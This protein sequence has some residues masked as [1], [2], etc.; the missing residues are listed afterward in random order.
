LAVVIALLVV[1][2]GATAVVWVNRT[3]HTKAATVT[4]TPVL[5]FKVIA[6]SPSPST[7]VVPSATNITVSFSAPIAQNSPKPTL[8]PPVPGDWAL[9][10]PSELEFVAS[11]PLVPGAT[12]SVVIPGGSAGM[13]S[14]QGQFLSTS[15]TVPFSVET[16]SILRLQ[17]LLAELGYLPLTFTP[18]APV[19]SLTQEADIQQGTFGWRWA[20]EPVS[21]T[22]L[23]TPGQMNVITRGAIMDFEDQ[24]GLTTDGQ[25]G[26]QVWTDLL[27]D[28][29]SG[30]ADS[31]PYRYVYVSENLPETVT[32]Y[33]D[34]AVVYTTLANTG[35]PGATTQQGT[36]PVFARYVTTTMTGTNVDGSKYSDPGVPWVS[37]FN[38]G[39]ALHGFVRGSY[40]FPQS[41][42]CVEMP[43]SNAAV[44]FPLTP[45]GTLVTV[46]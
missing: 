3:G 8:A 38:G 11:A 43:P 29:A 22:A 35:V 13:V 1:G 6:T 45:I 32:V 15:T 37:Y 21:L 26:P 5:A 25:P 10:S 12:E 17:Q 2:G 16:G 41:N 20:N 31:N 30:H 28:A 4:P 9:V 23:W 40:G 19:T 44:V 42:G 18:I 33:Q 36:F 27:A 39:D 24:H 46:G 34:N 14:E 7:K